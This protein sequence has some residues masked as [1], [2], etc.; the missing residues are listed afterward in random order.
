MID[1]GIAFNDTQLQAI[2]AALTELVKKTGWIISLS[3][4]L[5]NAIRDRNKYIE[6]ARAA[7]AQ[8]GLN[9]YQ[10]DS[11]LQLQASIANSECLTILQLLDSLLSTARSLEMLNATYSVPVKRSK[12]FPPPPLDEAMQ[13]LREISA[14]V[15]QDMP[16]L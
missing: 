12:L 9:F 16:A 14:G 2:L 8:G 1:G 4:I 10:L 3:R 11:V 6:T 15:I 13:K 5:N 7:A